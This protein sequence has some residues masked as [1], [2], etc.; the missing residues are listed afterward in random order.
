MELETAP[1]I[2]CILYAVGILMGCRDGAIPIP[3]SVIDE[4]YHMYSAWL[5]H[6]F[7]EQPPLLL[8]ASHTFTFDP[9]APNGCGQALKAQGHV[10]L[11][12]L[13]VLHDLGDAEYPVRIGNFQLAAFRIPWKYEGW[14]RQ[15][16]PS[17]AFR[18]I[19]F[20]RVAFNRDR[21]EALFAVSNSCGGLCGGGGALLAMR[22]DQ[23]PGAGCSRRE[24][25]GRPG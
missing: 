13:R 14:D 8:L 16:S 11:S 23:T 5:K 9:L 10:S 20:S 1:S 4:E 15:T 25:A 17:G 18:L 3:N 2:V 12:L 6:H 19:A 22:Q 21:S 7:K 24:W